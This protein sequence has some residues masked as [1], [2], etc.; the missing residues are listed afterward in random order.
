MASANAFDFKLFK[1]LLEFTRPYRLVFYFVAFTAV[2]LSGLAIF[3][4]YLTNVTHQGRIVVN[5]LNK[6]HGEMT[7][8]LI[9]SVSEFASYATSYLIMEIIA[10]FSMMFQILAINKILHSQFLTLGIG[11]FCIFLTLSRLSQ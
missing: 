4:C 6:N 11:M 8:D 9:L 3:P 2:V 1:R 7:T 5:F 10:F